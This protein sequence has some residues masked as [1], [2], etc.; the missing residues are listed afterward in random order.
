MTPLSFVT[1]VWICG[2]L[3][4]N[5]FLMAEHLF[6]CFWPCVCLLRKSLKSPVQILCLFLSWVVF[7]SLSYKT[8]LYFLDTSPLLDV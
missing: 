7:L 4:A 3:M 8:Y 2:F 5:V 1:V 6:I